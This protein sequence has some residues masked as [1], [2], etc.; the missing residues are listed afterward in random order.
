MSIEV[1][2]LTHIYNMNTSFEKIALEKVSVSIKKKEFVGIIG[3]TGSGKSTF[4]NMLNGLIEPSHGQI[5]VNGID[6]HG[7]NVNKKEI[8]QK[9]GLV[10]QYPE[11][12]LFEISVFK[13]VCY[14]PSNLGLSQQEIEKRA[15]DALNAVGLKQELWEK[16]PFELSGGQKRR[17]AIA[18]VLAMQP[19]ILILDEPTAGLDPKGRD[20]L[21]SQLRHMH[22]ELGLTIILVSHSMEDVARNVEHLIVLHGGRLVYDATPREIYKNVEHLE[23]IGLA[24]PQIKYIIRDLNKRGFNLDENILTVEEAATH[25]LKAIREGQ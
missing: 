8:R 11:Y 15:T 4:I 22:K 13:D 16:S 2:N 25:I 24:P 3:H 23:K 12:Q 6:I 9:V 1:K 14:G 20:E 7:E 19:E 21:F 10:F 17:V 5:L 18:G